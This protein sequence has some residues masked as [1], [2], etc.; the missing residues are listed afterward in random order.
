MSVPIVAV[1]AAESWLGP[2]GAFTAFGVFVGLTA[3][4]AMIVT[5][6][7]PRLRP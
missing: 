3:L 1:G 2:Q 6:R 4:V 7:G 5:V